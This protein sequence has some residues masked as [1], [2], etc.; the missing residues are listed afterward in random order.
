LFIE[1]NC[2][3]GVAAKTTVG[4]IDGATRDRKRSNLLP[5]TR[6]PLH[7]QRQTWIAGP[8]LVMKTCPSG[9]KARMGLGRGIPP[10]VRINEPVLEFHIFTSCPPGLS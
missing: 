1:K 8:I 7:D 2:L 5:A 4:L 6:R 10:K 3:I 9:L